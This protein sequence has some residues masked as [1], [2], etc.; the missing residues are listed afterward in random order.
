ME[1]QDSI[2]HVPAPVIQSK[3][4]P[5]PEAPIFAYGMVP[6]EINTQSRPAPQQPQQYRNPPPQ[7]QHRSPPPQQPQQYRNQPPQQQQRN[8]PPQYRNQQTPSQSPPQTHYRQPPPTNAR[9]YGQ[10]QVVRMQPQANQQGA[11]QFQDPT[12]Q[13]ASHHQ[14]GTQL[15]VIEVKQSPNTVSTQQKTSHT[16]YNKKVYT[17][18]VD[19]VKTQK[20]TYQ[21]RSVTKKSDSKVSNLRNEIS[22]LKNKLRNFEDKMKN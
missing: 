8:P 3:P 12:R 11:R 19:S 9:N 7:Q 14:T 6:E 2:K 5:E 13:V 1:F 15:R 22:H 17:R 18:T 16:G 4:E 21:K 10:P 20:Q